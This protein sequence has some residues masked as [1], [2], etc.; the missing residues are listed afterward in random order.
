MKNIVIIF[1]VVILAGIGIYFFTKNSPPKVDVTTDTTQQ[2]QSDI[3]TSETNDLVEGSEV[4]I[5]QS[6]EGRDITAYNY[7]EGDTQILFVGG[8]HGASLRMPG[9][10]LSIAQPRCPDRRLSSKRCRRT[11][12]PA[13]HRIA[14]DGGT[15]GIS[16]LANVATGA[17]IDIQIPV[18]PQFE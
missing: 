17:D 4:V 16:F 11:C 13:L 10:T 14:Q 1:L 2:S 5:G 8:I 18:R 15:H 6:V 3:E 12:L 7:G 9:K